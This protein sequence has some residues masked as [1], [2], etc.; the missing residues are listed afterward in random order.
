MNFGMTILTQRMETEQNCVIQIL[1]TLLFTLKPQ[2]FLKIFLM[3]LRDGLMHLTMIKM[4]K[5]PLPIGKNKKVHGLFK[6]ELVGKIIT[7][8]VALRPKTYAYLMDDG[9]D[10]KKTKGR[11]KC[12]KT[13]TYV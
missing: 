6:D 11:K 8:V 7:E 13:K 2:I 5:R 9:S 10:H 4:I 3:M 12:N 1:I